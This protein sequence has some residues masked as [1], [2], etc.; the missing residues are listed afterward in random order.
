[1]IGKKNPRIL[2]HL[3]SKGFDLSTKDGS[4]KASEYMATH[5]PINTGYGRAG[6]DR[7]IFKMGDNALYTSNSIPTAEGYTYG[8]GYIVKAKKPTD[9]SSPNR[10]DWITK[11][12]L[13]YSD[14]NKLEKLYDNF[15]RGDTEDILKDVFQR[16]S[17]HSNK[18]MLE[19]INEVKRRLNRQ[20]GMDTT[21][22]INILES[23]IDNFESLNNPKL[24]RTE[25]NDN[26]KYSHYIH[27]GKPGEQVLEPIKSV[28]ITPE[29]WKNK[30]R[31]HT[32]IYSKG[33]S[34]ASLIPTVGI[35]YGLTQ[36]KK[37]GGILKKPL[38]KK[39]Q[40]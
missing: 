28:E 18:T 19:K 5:I 23:N 26:T 35:G 9:F 24:V 17:V 25:R 2:E 10:Q 32:G 38:L 22:D 4:K 34:L 16:N 33:M 40:C 14:S 37:Q 8:Q 27:I 3:K 29:I 39:K 6:V 20:P 30:S 12:T 21:N 1:M 31:A 36:S 15:E 11:N 7:E 13:K